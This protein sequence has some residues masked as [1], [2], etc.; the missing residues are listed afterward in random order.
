M[1]K[2]L[3]FILCFTSIFSLFGCKKKDDILALSKNLT[4]YNIDLNLD[5]KNK[6]ATVKQ[7]INYINSTNSILK[8]LKMHLYVQNF[9]QGATSSVIASTK[10]NVAYP[11]GMDYAEFEIT[12]LLVNNKDT[13][14]VYEGEHNA[15]LSIDLFE[16]LMPND[17]SIIE[18]E[19]NFKL[20]NCNHRFGYGNNT[21]NLANFY[22]ILCV[23]ENGQFNTNGYNSNGDPFYSDMANYRVDITTDKQY[24][25]AGTGEKTQSEIDN[26]L[27]KT[28]FSAHLVRDFAMVV[29]NKFEVIR[30]QYE[31]IKIEYYYFDET[32]ASSNLK[33]GVDAIKTFC[34]L[35]GNY[36]YSTYSIVKADF[37]HGGME[38]PNLVM[39]SSS[40][41]NEDDCKNVIVHETAH[42]WWYAI[43]GNDEY[44]YPWLDEALTEFSTIL[45]YDN[46]DGYN[47]NHKD[48]IDASKENYSLFI[49]VYEDVLGKIDTSMR[50]VNEYSTEPEYTYCTYV[51]GTLMFESLY[52]LVGKD[53]FVK[54]LK[55]YYETYKFKNAIPENLISA[56][57]K[58]CKQKLN[59]FFESWTA[60]RVVIR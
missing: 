38:Y 10:L 57:E 17:R 14:I 9:K 20:P 50:A 8:N 58:V 15:I 44:N 24:I 56:F 30:E 54:S 48:M 40:I 45:F 39:I 33:A 27:T 3:I 43:V 32:N 34:K 19:Y 6:T 41:E 2:I 31:N 29:S 37:V 59:S 1:K 23:Y 4:E 13:T 46:T 36:P 53:K 16:S 18:L 7:K 51:K 55:D 42:Q 22:P 35:F 52:Q 28:S 5:A 21:I 49:T 11:N 60:G 47:L 12:R 26:N 25:V